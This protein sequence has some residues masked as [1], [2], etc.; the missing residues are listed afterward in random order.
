MNCITIDLVNIRV[1]IRLGFMQA[2]LD[3]LSKKLSDSV[4]DDDGN[5]PRA[6]CASSAQ[7]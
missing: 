7:S 4:K 1:G 5:E 2:K 6:P 3:F